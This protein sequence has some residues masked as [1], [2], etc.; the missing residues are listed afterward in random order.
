M[1]VPEEP[2]PRATRSG[3]VPH[4]SRSFTSAP[5]RIIARTRAS[6]PRMTAL[7]SSLVCPKRWIS[8]AQV[9]PAARNATQ[10][11]EAGTK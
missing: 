11:S 1:A 2:C 9:T 10:R 7:R 5:S 4:Q 6:S 3:E 8:D